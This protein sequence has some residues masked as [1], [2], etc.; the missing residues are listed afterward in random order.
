MRVRHRIP[1]IFS[2]SMVDMLCCALGCVILVWLLNA[3]QHE[4][5]VEERERAADARGAEVRAEREKGAAELAAL[6]AQRDQASAQLANVRAD[7]ASAYVQLA[8]LEGRAR[9]LEGERAALSK[10]LAER[11]AAAADLAGKLKASAARVAALE[12]DVRAGVERVAQEKARLAGEKERGAALGERLGRAEARLRDLNRELEQAR[13]GRGEQELLAGELRQEL[14][15]RGVELK[16]LNRNLDDLRAAGN[17]LRAT[18]EARDREL[19]QARAYREKWASADERARGLEKQLQERQQELGAVSRSVTALQAERAAL[20]GE[21]GRVRAAAAARF[22]GIELTGQNVIFLVDTSGS[23]EMLDEA[24]A[25][26]HKW[27]EVC[28]TVAR[29]MRSLPDLKKFQ[30][31]TF[32]A[33]PAFPLG[34][35]GRWLEADGRAS[36]EKVSKALRAIKPK[37]G[38]N[39]YAALEAALRYRAQ[40]LDTVYLLSDGLPNQGPGL[41]AAARGLSEVQRGAILGKHIRD[42]LKADWNRGREGQPRVRINTVGFFYESPDLGAFLWALARE[43]EGSFVGMS[44]P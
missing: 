20:R 41:P 10:Q 26:P 29:L 36:V 42:T 37:G 33:K 18:L 15:R 3:K 34:Q 8:E 6:R 19:A 5:D 16:A 2:L 40:G 11:R 17:L 12:A 27:R 23:M 25:A 32:A 7:R 31:I 9:A 38:T 44:R 35:E 22:A 13:K 14:A 21:V 28:E 1:A 39:M 43:H 30:V 24:T 4:D